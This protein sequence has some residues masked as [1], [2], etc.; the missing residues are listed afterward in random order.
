VVNTHDMVLVACRDGSHDRSGPFSR[1]TAPEMRLLTWY[2]GEY[3]LHFDFSS[4]G[5]W[6]AVPDDLGRSVIFNM[7]DLTWREVKVGAPFAWYPGR[8]SLLGF[9]QNG[10]LV[11]LDVAQANP[12]SDALYNMEHDCRTGN[13]AAVWVHPAADSCVTISNEG[14]WSCAREA[15]SLAERE[16]AEL[17]ARH[18]AYHINFGA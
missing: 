9:D 15:A 14:E 7:H 2:W 6:L 11:S 1:G 8:P 5:C 16:G 17:P 13:I 4:D 12:L 3:Y 18:D 10:W